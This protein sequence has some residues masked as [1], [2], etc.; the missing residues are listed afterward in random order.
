MLWGCFVCLLTYLSAGLWEET[1][2]L[3]SV[4]I[5]KLKP[6]SIMHLDPAMGGI[7]TDRKATLPTVCGAPCAPASPPSPGLPQDFW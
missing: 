6:D 1:R 4:I 5:P 2:D 3:I 7:P